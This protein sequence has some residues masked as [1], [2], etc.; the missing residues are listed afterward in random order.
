MS[1][2]PNLLKEEKNNKKQLNILMKNITNSTNQFF[3]EAV[4]IAHQ[5]PTFWGDTICQPSTSVCTACGGR[6]VLHFLI[7]IGLTE[8]DDAKSGYRI[9]FYFNENSYFKSKILTKEFHLNES[10]DSPSKAK[11]ASR[12]RQYEEPESFFTWFTCHS[13]VGADELGVAIIDDIWPNTLQYYLIPD[14][15]DEEGEGE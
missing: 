9:D 15:D 11:K 12:K 14:I 3:S 8:V 1:A 7:G 10:G 13:D 2:S 4:R 6:R 5:N